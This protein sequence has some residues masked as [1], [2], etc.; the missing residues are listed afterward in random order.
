MNNANIQ[1]SL[2]VAMT[3]SELIAILDTHRREQRLDMKDAVE[4]VENGLRRDMEK[5]EDNLKEDNAELKAELKADIR[6]VKLEL[7][8]KDGVLDRL[9]S[10]EESTRE[11]TPVSIVHTRSKKTTKEKV[12]EHGA[13]AAIVAIVVPIVELIKSYIQSKQ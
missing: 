8:R 9:S 6:D 11:Q 3:D 1:S 5:V 7:T 10:L 13:T 12:V 4:H 2:G